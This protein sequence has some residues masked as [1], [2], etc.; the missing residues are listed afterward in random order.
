MQVF[1]NLKAFSS[2]VFLIR[3]EL[4]C[5]LHYCM[6]LLL[7]QVGNEL[8]QLNA[9]NSRAYEWATCP[10]SILILVTCLVSYS[11]YGPSTQISRFSLFYDCFFPYQIVWF[12]IVVCVHTQTFLFSSFHRRSKCQRTKRRRWRKNKRSRQSC[13]RKGSR[14]WRGERNLMV[15]RKR[16]TRR[17]QRPQTIQ[18]PQPAFPCLLLFKISPTTQAQVRELSRSWSWSWLGDIT[19]GLSKR[20]TP[21]CLCFESWVFH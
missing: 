10:N 14:R 1:R 18:R 17:P 5:G 9:S 16:M 2:N 21:S 4:F 13:W 15:V 11:E 8:N 7:S 19:S 12:Q 6:S 20:H 3:G